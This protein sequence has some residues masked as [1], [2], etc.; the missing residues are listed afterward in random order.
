MVPHGIPWLGHVAPYHSSIK[1][2]VSECHLSSATNPK[3][4][5]HHLPLQRT[6]VRPL[7]R[8]RTNCHINL[9]GL[10]SQCPFFTCLTIRTDR[11]IPRSRCLFE[12]KWVALGSQRRG[13]HSRSIWSDSE[14]FE[15]LSKIWSPDHQWYQ[16]FKLATSMYKYATKRL[17][18]VDKR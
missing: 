17:L 16:C 4:P 9:Y 13:L 10:P 5:R 18:F 6:D 15:F 14:H 1:C 7:P 12:P 3:L 2:H 11:D 8:H